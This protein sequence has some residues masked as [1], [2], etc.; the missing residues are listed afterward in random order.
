MTLS[1]DS[2]ENAAIDRPFAGH[3]QQVILRQTAEVVKQP[4][5]DLKQRPQ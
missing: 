2:A 1:V 4:A 3:V 5:I